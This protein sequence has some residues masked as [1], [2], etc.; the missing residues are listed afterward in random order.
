MRNTLWQKRIPTLLGLIMILVGIG[1][2]TYL[3][4]TG[5]IVTTKAGPTENPQNV[6]ITNITG[7]SITVSYTT[8]AQVIGSVNYGRDE[9]LGQT[10]L[11]DRDVNGNVVPRFT[12]YITIKNLEPLTDYYF[13]I[14]SGAST[15]K[16]GENL[17][18][19]MSG[20]NIGRPIAEENLIKGSIIYPQ[21]IPKESIIYISAQDSDTISAVV[22]DDGSFSILLD[23]LKAKDL[24]S[25]FGF[26]ENSVFEGLVQGQNN[27]SNVKFTIPQNKEL[28]PI[29][30]SENFDFTQTL[31][32]DNVNSE[33][34]FSAISSQGQTVSTDIQINTPEKN[35][36]FI[37]P[38]PRFT[39][40]ALPDSTI[41]IQIH[42]DDNIKAQITVD[43]RGNW[44]YRP[45]SNLSP[46]SHTITISARDSSGILRTITQAFTIFES[47]TQVAEAATP[48]ATPIPTIPSQ[49]ITSSPTP[50]SI[51]LPTSTPTPTLIPASTIS[52]TIPPSVPPSP[53]ISL[54]LL[55]IIGIGITGL[56]A[57]ILFYNRNTPI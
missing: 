56:G 9:N 38:Q 14:T 54:T 57:L 45:P 2:T 28:A 16:Q 51:I 37:D 24:S 49:T 52:P 19:I 42:S 26:N 12:H 23:M 34:N 41:S 30:L 29:T 20:P 50:T 21:E 46:G 35:Q 4:G 27:I 44:S 7:D 36:E 53:G 10:T 55:G 39:G 43:A 33:E 13:S 40:T 22:K 17:Y 47:G 5:T 1:I 32:S 48:S 25:Y 11:D 8:Q 18:K 6:R 3:V 15:Y 31:P